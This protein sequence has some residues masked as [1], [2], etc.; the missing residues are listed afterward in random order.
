MKI[1]DKLAHLKNELSKYERV[2]VAFSG[3]VD[4]TLLLHLTAQIVGHKNVIAITGFSDVFFESDLSFI[5]EYTKQNKIKLAIVKTNQLADK[6]FTSNGRYRCYYCRKLFFDEIKKAALKFKAKVLFDGLNQ[7]DLHDYR[8]GRKAAEEAGIISPFVAA[9]ITKDEIRTLAKSEGIAVWGKPSSP[10]AATRIAYNIEI[11]KDRL[12]RIKILEQMLKNI[13][14]LQVRLRDHG[15]IARIE[16]PKKEISKLINHKEFDKI[17]SE[18]RSKGFHW[19]TV[20][21][22]G[23]ESGSMN[24][25][26]KNK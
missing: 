19:V 7:D 1:T 16:V 18:I 25:S 23:F 13:G 8:P 4:S 17:V 26:I 12:D 11:T 2:A 9:S 10:C 14:F 3:G 20:D 22:G 15:D 24:R 5:K 6:K 21:A